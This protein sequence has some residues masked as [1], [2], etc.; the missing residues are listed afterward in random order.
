[1]E[2]K[3]CYSDSELKEFKA[4]VLGK[5]EIAKNE[6]KVLLSSLKPH[7]DS[8]KLGEAAAD[9]LERETNNQLAAR[10]KKFVEQLEGALVRIEN[11]T[12]GICRETGTLIPKERLIAMPH[13][14][15]CMAAKLKQDERSYAAA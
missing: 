9:N 7:E 15:L 14:T 6:L 11:K 10:Q 1:M 2:T 3:T 5:L 13:A 12:Y 4:I 8:K